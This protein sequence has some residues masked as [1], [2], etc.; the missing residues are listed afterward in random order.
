L[1]LRDVGD[2]DLGSLVLRVG[3]LYSLDMLMGSGLV[4][5]RFYS[6]KSWFSGVDGLYSFEHVPLKQLKLKFM[7]D[8]FRSYGCVVDKKDDGVDVFNCADR[9]RVG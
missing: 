8:G 9:M 6:S 1:I 3:D 7:Y 4:L 5:D 2:V